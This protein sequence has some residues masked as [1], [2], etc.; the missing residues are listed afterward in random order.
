MDIEG[1]GEAIVDQLVDRGLLRDYG[2]IYALTLERVSRLERMADK[3]A[4]NLIEA[5][6]RSKGR[7]ADRLV[8][9]LGIRHVGSRAARILADHFGSVDALSRGSLEALTAI[10]GVG[11]VMAQSVDNYFRNRSNQR[12]LKKLRE[13]GVMM[14]MPSA[15][16]AA[17]GPLAGKVVVLTGTLKGFTRQEAESLLKERGALPSS[18]VGRKTDLVVAG[19][20]AGSKLAR[21]KELGIRV[22][23]EEEF[24]QMARP[25]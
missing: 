10:D 23:G 14:R 5:I 13:A 16:P 1:M 24:K 11:P 15:R 20:G 25:S 7:G 6:E 19:E 17:K 9:G 22:I 8:Y 12:I 2:D 21:A 3:S 18:S 4:G